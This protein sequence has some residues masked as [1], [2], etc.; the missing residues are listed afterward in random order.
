[1]LSKISGLSLIN[2]KILHIV[3]VLPLYELETES[4]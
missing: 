1:L 4:V 2:G 3:K